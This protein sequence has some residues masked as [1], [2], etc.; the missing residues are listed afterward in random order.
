M[1]NGTSLAFV[2]SNGL[3]SSSLGSFVASVLNKNVVCMKNA[4]GMEDVSDT[5]HCD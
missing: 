2:P 3:F 1:E 5:F 4:T